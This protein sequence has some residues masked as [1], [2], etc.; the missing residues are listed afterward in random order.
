MLMA[1]LIIL[2]ASAALSALTMFV[3]FRMGRVRAAEDMPEDC[4]AQYYD[5]EG[6]H[7]HYDYDR[8]LIA[9]QKKERESG[10]DKQATE[11]S[12]IQ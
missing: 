8:K 6:N 7:I 5:A 1:I 12:N 3:L 4:D 10:N 9:L 11:S 2:T